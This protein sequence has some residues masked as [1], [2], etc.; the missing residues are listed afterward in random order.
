[1]KSKYFAPLLFLFLSLGLIA[2]TQSR[3]SQIKFEKS[4]QEKLLSGKTSTV[5]VLMKAKAYLKPAEQLESK[6][7]KGRF[8]YEAL[9]QVALESQKDL[10]LMLDDKKVSYH[11]FYIANLIELRNAP[12]ELVA[13]IAKRPDVEKIYDN[14]YFTVK[15]P[16]FNQ[17]LQ[18]P[19][20]LKLNHLNGNSK[21]DPQ[22]SL[23]R[24]NAVRAWDE[25]GVKGKGI[26]VAGEDSGI[27]WDHPALIQHYRGDATHHD[28]NWHDAIRE[29]LKAKQNPCGYDLASPCDDGGHG[30]HTMGTVVGNDGD[31]N[32][33]GVAPEAQWI[34]CRNMD[35]GTGSP[36]SYIDCFEFFL[37]PYAYHK[38]PMLDGDPTK[39]PHV[40]NNSW[41]CPIAEGCSG[42]EMIPVLE[43][44]Q[45]AGIFVVASAGN[46]GPECSSVADQP[47]HLSSL[48]FSVGALAEKEDT[49]AFFSSRGPSILT[50]QTVP[51]LT[52]PGTNIRSSVPGK[53]YEGGWSG[54]SMAGPHV[55]GVVALLWSAAPKLI[56]H[57]KETM[58]LLRET[59]KPLTST[60]TC[61]TTPGTQIPNNTFGYGLIDAH[62]AILKARK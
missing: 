2:V 36:A 40:I 37:A 30:T 54:T 45:S 29:P 32:I 60:Q 19:P 58:S 52:A 34:G 28:F 44:L 59:A 25:L 51:D 5:L 21:A 46:D 53:K 9:R 48:A 49:I 24:V 31:Q 8:V 55:T 16:F 23:V 27:E 20:S 22:A 12:F 42:R 1:M 4:L 6:N 35:E 47:A 41:G 56:G 26:V 39:S 7:E 13:E 43:A 18:D 50:G 62:A 33:I 38:N 15:S 11:R 17:H 10:V 61:G 57:V 14:P 3:S